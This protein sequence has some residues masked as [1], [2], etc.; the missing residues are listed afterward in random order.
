MP[1]MGR[2]QGCVD[3]MDGWVSGTCGCQEIVGVRDNLIL[4]MCG[5][6]GDA[7]G[8]WMLRV[9][10]CKDMLVAWFVADRDVRDPSPFVIIRALVMYIS[11]V[12]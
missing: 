7:R 5:C 8:V 9:C 10:G 12:C 1:E 11:E 4:G 6:Q 2:C 3:A